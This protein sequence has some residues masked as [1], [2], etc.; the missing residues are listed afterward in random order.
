MVEKTKNGWRDGKTRD[1]KV[2][3][4]SYH[5]DTDHYHLFEVTE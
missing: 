2:D 5:L 3:R 4:L 1:I